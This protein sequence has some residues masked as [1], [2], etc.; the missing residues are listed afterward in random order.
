MAEF[1]AE[2]KRRHIYRVGAAYVVV[3]WVFTQVIDVLSQVFELPGWIAQPAVAVLAVGLPVA[4]I[5]AWMIESRPHEAVVSAVR[6]KATVLDGALFGALII[7][8]LLIGYG[9][10]ASTQQAGV[11]AARSASLDLRAGISLAVLPFVNLS[12]DE[13]QVFFSDGITE[14]ITTALAR[15][16][17][18]R[19][20]ARTSAFEFKGQNRNI[21]TIGQQLQATHLIEGSVRRAGD[22][23]R[24]TAQLIN[25]ANGTHL[26]SENYDRQLLDVF[27]IQE[28]IATAI[29]ASLR[30]PL[31][32]APGQR[33]VPSRTITAEDYQDYL[34]TRPLVRQRAAGVPRAIQILEP[35][36]ARN[37][38]FAPALAQLAAAYGLS[39]NYAR[40]GTVEELRRAVDTYLP[41]A[42]TMARRV[43]QL[44]ANLPDAYIAL[45]RVEGVRGRF[46]AAEALYEKAL[47]LD[48]NHPDTLNQ[49]ASLLANVGR[50]KEALA[51]SE[52]RRE[53]EPFIPQYNSNTAETL[54]LNGQDDAAIAMLRAMPD[55]A[56]SIADLAMIYAAR[57][58]HDQSLQSLQSL[59]AKGAQIGMQ[60]LRSQAQT[61]IAIL[62]TAPAKLTP[63]Q[64]MPYLHRLQFVY[65][66]VGE[67]G[68]MM[69]YYEFSGQTGLYAP[70]GGEVA[71]LWHPSF[72]PVRQTER[73]KIWARAAGLLEYWRAKGWPETCRPMGTNDFDCS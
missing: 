4:L 35:L 13:S 44:D 33:L 27:A 57:G 59:E 41:K 58:E 16:P 9:R 1:F 54:W 32:L 61:A 31:G 62:R 3:A 46:L 70:S 72:S 55:D 69:E 21:Q 42:E 67:P 64:T 18:L 71:L 10:I 65:R 11:N 53:V 26:W 56:T 49:Y 52:R 19:V 36:V 37:P 2:L 24:I 6:S 47:A 20:V 66:Y 48:P 63:G 8:G 40:N 22:R 28:D 34:R 5:A 50:L 45:G 29:A 30:M 73:F 17:D 51:M 14:E 68:R 38:D 43:I 23:V 7:V 39:P 60:L 15:I 25:A 12:D